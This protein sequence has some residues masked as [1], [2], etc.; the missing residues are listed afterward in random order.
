MRS[1]PLCHISWPPT[2]PPPPPRVNICSWTRALKLPRCESRLEASLASQTDDQRR[3]PPPPASLT[4][5]THSRQL[6][7]AAPPPRRSNVPVVFSTRPSAAT[8]T[9]QPIPSAGPIWRIERST[10]Y[11]SK[12]LPPNGRGANWPRE[13]TAAP[14]FEGASFCRNWKTAR[15]FS[16]TIIG[17]AAGWRE[18][19]SLGCR[20]RR[21]RRQEPQLGGRATARRVASG[22]DDSWKTIIRAH[23]RAA[24]CRRGRRARRRRGARRRR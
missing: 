23:A 11:Q 20:C 13:A 24:S 17:Y 7:K 9:E 19:P 22:D 4:A 21:R 15:D 5:I 8:T 16:E 1:W 14:P 10:E 3:R 18:K 2:S 12:F 6:R